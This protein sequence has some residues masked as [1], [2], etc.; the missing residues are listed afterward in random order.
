MCPKNGLEK[1]I[2]NQNYTARN[3]HNHC[4]KRRVLC[5]L[6]QNGTENQKLK[7]LEIKITKLEMFLTT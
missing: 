5:S 4:I 6:S 1:K 7:N 3:V 2:G